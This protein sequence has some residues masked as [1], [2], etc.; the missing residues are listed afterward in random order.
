MLVNHL[1]YLRGYKWL[2]LVRST[3][4]PR[5]GSHTARRVVPFSRDGGVIQ[6]QKH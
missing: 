3:P 5:A 4:F 6:L 2:F 1:G